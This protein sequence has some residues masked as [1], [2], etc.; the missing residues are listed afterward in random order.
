[1]IVIP[2]RPPPAEQTAEDHPFYLVFRH[3]DDPRVCVD[4]SSGS[5][6]INEPQLVDHEALTRKTAAVISSALSIAKYV[7]NQP[8]ISE[9]SKAGLHHLKLDLVSAS[10]FAWRTVHNNMLMR[11]SIAL[12]SLSGTIP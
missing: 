10:N 5:F 7:F 11:P 2:S 1:M 9:E 6:S 8:E 3:P 4:I 12:K